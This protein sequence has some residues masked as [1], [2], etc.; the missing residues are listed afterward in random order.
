LQ[1]GQRLLVVIRGISLASYV[2]GRE[3]LW[4]QNDFMDGEVAL[5]DAGGRL[6]ATRK[7]LVQS[8]ASSGGAWYIRGG[9][10]RRTAALSQV[11]AAWAR[12]YLS[13]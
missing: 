7:L 6:L 1:P 2:G 13:S 4:P 12:R 3:L 10:L 8:P 9:E 11:F 5:F